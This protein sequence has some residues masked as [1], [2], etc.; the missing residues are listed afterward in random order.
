MIGTSD[1]A[2]AAKLNKLIWRI[3]T[4]KHGITLQQDAVEFLLVKLT[5]DGSTDLAMVEELIEF[6]AAAFVKQENRPNLVDRAVLQ[7]HVDGILKAVQHQ[8]DYGRV[9]GRQYMHVLNSRDVSKWD[10]DPHEKQFNLVPAKTFSKSILCAPTDRVSAYV[11]RFHMCRQRLLRHERFCTV[12]GSGAPLRLSSI[13]SVK[14]QAFKEPK[15]LFGM[16]AQIVEG[17]YSL[18]DPEDHV[19]LD[20][21]QVQEAVAGL[22]TEGAFVLIEG[23]SQPD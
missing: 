8:Q 13:K 20:F 15:V 11:R 10:Y 18:E 2:R 14:G 3:F 23:F 16:L 9:D 12:A 19:R 1:G 4:K 6:V 7:V 17:Q 22:Y 21:S 5:S